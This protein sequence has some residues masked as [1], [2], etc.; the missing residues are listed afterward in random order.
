MKT[1]ESHRNLREDGVRTQIITLDY[2]EKK[3]EVLPVG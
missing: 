1:E 3:V 2:L